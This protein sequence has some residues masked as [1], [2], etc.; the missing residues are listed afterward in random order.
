MASF[1]FDSD[2]SSDSYGYDWTAE[3][4]AAVLALADGIESTQT[5][6]APLP[7]DQELSSDLSSPEEEPAYRHEI[8]SEVGLAGKRRRLSPPA[9]ENSPASLSSNDNS[10]ARPRSLPT[11][12]DIE[13][14]AINYPDL[15]RALSDVPQ[16]TDSESQAGSGTAS[17]TS[18]TNVP[19]II[20]FRTFPRKP[21]SVSDLIAGSWC[22]LQYY[23]TLTR[24]P[25][26][27]RTRT[28]AMKGGTKIHKKLEDEVHI[29]VPIDTETGEDRFGVRIWN[30]IRGLRTLRDTGLTR[31][32][33][34][35]GTVDGNLVNGVIDG[36]SY[37][38][39]DPE[40]EEDVLITRGSQSSQSS[41]RN[42]KITEYFPPG[43]T[44]GDRPIFI[45]DVKTRGS[46][47]P[48]S[49]TAV[50]VTII[51]LFLYH[52]F[53]SEMASDK[54]DYIAIFGRYGLDP[55]APFSDGFMA[56]IGDL[57]GEIFS[58]AESTTETTDSNTA[59]YA[60]AASSPSKIGPIFDD[61]A[62][63]GTP[64]TLKYRTLRALLSLLKFEIQLTFPKGANS[65]GQIVAVEYRHRARSEDDPTN[66]TVICVN[67]HF[68]E[69]E[70]LDMYLKDDMQWWRGER[71][72]RGVALEEAEKCQSCEFVADCEWRENLDQ[73]FMRKA[74]QKDKKRESSGRS[75]IKREDSVSW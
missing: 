11:A 67:T 34:V 23:Y 30:L 28:V 18:D 7:S 62:T 4:E 63:L 15:S 2:T 32:L 27:R 46:W 22:E 66:G 61:A 3:E 41:Q 59:D 35:W 10:Q 24:L 36:L 12:T 70:I 13:N 5:P 60:S 74:K 31:E 25:G 50:R 16:T 54:L 56:Q 72:P 19:P 42:Q 38:N 65:L 9:S 40:L 69:P 37:D 53:L 39:P 52:R 71:E 51:Q 47:N 48:P 29:T 73:E 33:E 1:A 45:T 26:G 68:V 17:T 20:R 55:D 49:K 64:E 8:K 21:F 14:A 57:Y 75:W 6:L 44:P 58:D 43:G